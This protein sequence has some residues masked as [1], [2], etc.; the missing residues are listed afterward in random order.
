MNNT[1]DNMESTKRTVSLAS[2]GVIG[3]YIFSK[4]NAAK[5]LQEVVPV[6]NADLPPALKEAKFYDDGLV[7][8]DSVKRMSEIIAEQARV[9]AATI[10]NGIRTP[11]M[12]NEEPQAEE[13]DTPAEDT[14]DDVND[15]TDVNEITPDSFNSEDTDVVEEEIEEDYSDELVDASKDA[16]PV[17]EVPEE[18]PVEEV[19]DEQDNNTAD[20][21]SDADQNNEYPMLD[22]DDDDEDEDDIGVDEE[23][24]DE[25]EI[26][27]I[28]PE[29]KS[30]VKLSKEF[31]E[32]EVVHEVVLE[33]VVEKEVPVAAAV[34][35][36]NDADATPVSFADMG[37]FEG[38][39][40]PVQ[41]GNV[42][43]EPA[44][45]AETALPQEP[46]QEA[47]A[48]QPSL[49]EN[50]EPLHKIEE[51]DPADKETFHSIANFLNTLE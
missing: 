30:K 42:A 51:E 7:S 35:V 48:V 38:V 31:V 45:P 25:D 16:E 6:G 24:E 40:L 29:T 21:V 43:F 10:R 9:Y 46:V 3:Y 22:M 8:V 13:N 17:E 15:E 44:V 33:T 14:S 4:L 32:T 20:F 1:N 23:V 34:V 39:T 50:V 19:N 2:S 12:V 47:P 37:G 41:K 11:I 27:D 5:D 49:M 26:E 18:E 28:E 36:T